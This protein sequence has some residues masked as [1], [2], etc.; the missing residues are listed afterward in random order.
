[1]EHIK[2]ITKVFNIPFYEE[3]KHR[4]T[5]YKFRGK[6][7]T[8]AS[9]WLYFIDKLPEEGELCMYFCWEDGISPEWTKNFTTICGNFI[10]YAECREINGKGTEECLVFVNV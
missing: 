1:M 7:G 8:H 6:M 4:H 3:G 5:L 2:T 9:T 10:H